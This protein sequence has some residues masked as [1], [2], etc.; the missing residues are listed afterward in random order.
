MACGTEL[1]RPRR[2]SSLAGRESCCSQAGASAGVARRKERRGILMRRSRGCAVRSNNRGR[3]Q[4]I[5]LLGRNVAQ[6]FVCC[7][8]RRRTRV[9]LQGD[10]DD[11]SRRIKLGLQKGKKCIAGKWN[12]SAAILL[13]VSESN[14]ETLRALCLRSVLVQTLSS[15]SPHF[16]SLVS[17]ARMRQP[18]S[19]CL[20][21]SATRTF[22]DSLRW[23]SR[24]AARVFCVLL[25]LANDY[26]PLTTAR[27]VSVRLGCLAALPNPK[28]SSTVRFTLC[29]IAKVQP[30][31]SWQPGCS[32]L[33]LLRQ[34]APSSIT[35]RLESD[36]GWG[37][38]V[39]R[40]RR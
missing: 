8:S 28:A 30:R 24:G 27:L 20:Q 23:S 11:E 18:N 14:R 32:A 36:D 6:D 1:L 22:D 3:I 29:G 37:Q 19:S 4:K 12:L 17:L 25:S 9:P 16:L 33:D 26:S 39:V 5:R 21:P 15:G 10:S 7:R 40:G 34:G 38:A 31:A 2:R 35:R 13:P